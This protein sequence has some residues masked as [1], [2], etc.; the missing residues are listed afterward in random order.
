MV[1]RGV[2]RAGRFIDQMAVLVGNLAVHFE[3]QP[4]QVTAVLKRALDRPLKRLRRLT[5][6]KP[7]FT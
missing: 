3:N 7:L 6:D 1:L 4:Q 2:A 5:N